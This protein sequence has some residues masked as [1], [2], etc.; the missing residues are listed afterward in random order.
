MYMARKVDKMD[1]NT[2]M[3]HTH[4]A[5]ACFVNLLHGT[6]SNLKPHTQGVQRH[7]M[8]QQKSDSCLERVMS[9]EARGPMLLIF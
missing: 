7:L 4:K 6:A 5:A 9:F 2:P 1:D 8:L 3:Y